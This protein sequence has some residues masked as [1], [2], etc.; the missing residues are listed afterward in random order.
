MSTFEESEEEVF[1]VD[2]AAS[3]SSL[4]I[5]EAT[6][7]GAEW[8]AH[9]GQAMPT[10]QQLV[11]N[12]RES[13]KEVNA[14]VG[15]ADTKSIP[16]T[17]ELHQAD[18]QLTSDISPPSLHVPR[19]PYSTQDGDPP[20]IGDILATAVAR[21]KGAN[22]FEVVRDSVTG[23][24]TDSLMH[25]KDRPH[26]EARNIFTVCPCQ[27]IQCSCRQQTGS[28]SLLLKQTCFRSA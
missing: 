4:E 14:R 20:G 27:K 23:E 11:T 5:T 18:P 15:D 2:I 1:S 22:R 3:S 12:L 10:I 25:P 21:A 7:H 8:T 13:M 24:P 9:T 19:P 26:A 16:Q 28:I 17:A 6:G